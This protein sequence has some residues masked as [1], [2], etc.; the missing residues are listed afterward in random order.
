M[1]TGGE[2][3][4]WLHNFLLE[5][6]PELKRRNRGETEVSR[7]I[8]A[9]PWHG[10]KVSKVLRFEVGVSRSLLDCGILF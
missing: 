9:I 8:V 2:S 7:M 1:Q 3:F 4:S 6:V 5:T 10:E